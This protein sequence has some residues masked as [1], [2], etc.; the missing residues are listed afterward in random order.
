MRCRRMYRIACRETG[1]WGTA[2][3]AGSAAGGE[4]PPAPRTAE[5]ARPDIRGYPQNRCH[6]TAATKPQPPPP[7]VAAFLAVPA[8]RDP[9]N[10]ETRLRAV[11]PA[12]SARLGR[13]AHRASSPTSTIRPNIFFSRVAARP[14]ARASATAIS[15][16]RRHRPVSLGSRLEATVPP[17]NVRAAGETRPQAPGRPFYGSATKTVDSRRN[18]VQWQFSVRA[19]NAW[20]YKSQAIFVRRVRVFRTLQSIQLVAAQRNTAVRGISS[21]ILSSRTEN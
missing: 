11:A 1:K 5:P 8:A 14:S 19:P 13:T 10:S 17:C 12:R 21:R 20:S 4:Q 7:R 15:C 16:V 3:P 2:G 6:K 18:F 9:T